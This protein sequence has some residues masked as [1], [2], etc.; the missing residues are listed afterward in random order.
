MNRS[1]VVQ[2]IADR[3][4]MPA[5]VVDQ[6]L[7][8]FMEVVTNSLAIGHPVNIR[9]FGKFEPRYRKPVTRLNPLTRE[10][11]DVPATTSVAFVPSKNLKANI[12]SPA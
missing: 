4:G 7:G 12:N 9:T 8:S 11:I 2:A 1:D 6:I 5:V 10:P 3:E